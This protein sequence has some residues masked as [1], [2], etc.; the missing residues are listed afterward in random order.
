MVIV[1]ESSNSLGYVFN[2]GVDN[3]NSSGNYVEF[4]IDDG[5][6]SDTDAA[7]YAVEISGTSGAYNICYD[8]TK[9]IYSSKNDNRIDVSSS[10]LS[11]K[12]NLASP[13]CKVTFFSI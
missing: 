8:G 5:V 10:P 9:Y 3:V 7:S 12:T 6:I 11:A 4:S 13:F 1:Y 2:P